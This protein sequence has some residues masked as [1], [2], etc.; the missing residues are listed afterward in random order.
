MVNCL[1][2]QSW[3]VSIHVQRFPCLSPMYSSHCYSVRCMCSL[4]LKYHHLLDRQLY[5]KRL[6]FDHAHRGSI[7]QNWKYSFV[8]SMPSPLLLPQAH[9]S[10]WRLS[11]H[12]KIQLCCF[13]RLCGK[14]TSMLYLLWILADLHIVPGC[15]PA[16]VQG[17]LQKF[18]LNTLQEIHVVCM[19]ANDIHSSFGDRTLCMWQGNI[20]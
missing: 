15:H 13:T 20:G 10:S 6:D 19:T 2:D 5:Y 3:L 8:L 12:G 11:H 1:L 17:I 18:H 4:V 14:K 9:P 16:W 7:Q